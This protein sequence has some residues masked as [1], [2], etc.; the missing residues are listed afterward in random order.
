M[1]LSEIEERLIA[2]EDPSHPLDD[3]GRTH[4]LIGDAASDSSP[5][6]GSLPKLEV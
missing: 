2:M 5:I 1:E 6:L 3:K 4:G